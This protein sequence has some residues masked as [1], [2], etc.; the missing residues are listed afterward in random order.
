MELENQLLSS[1]CYVW[2]ILNVAAAPDQQGNEAESPMFLQSS[3]DL[4]M[5]GKGLFLYPFPH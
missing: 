1:Y 3:V 5:K 2:V 4:T